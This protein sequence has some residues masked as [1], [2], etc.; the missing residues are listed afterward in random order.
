MGAG[1]PP[2]WPATPKVVVAAIRLVPELAG[3]PL[4]TLPSWV[5][6]PPRV[7]VAADGVG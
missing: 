1:D 4:D 2:P 6:L 5:D 7:T 3:H